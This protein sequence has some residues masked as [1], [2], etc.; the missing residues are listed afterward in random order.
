MSTTDESTPGSPQILDFDREDL[1]DI[2]FDR[3]K[4]GHGVKEDHPFADTVI[5]QSSNSFS[6]TPVYGA[7]QLHKLY[8]KHSIVM[9]T[10][11][12]AL[13]SFPGVTTTPVEKTP[14]ITNS[15]FVPLSKRLAGIPGVLV[16]SIE[17]GALKLEW[18]GFEYLVFAVTFPIGFGTSQQFF[19]L[20]EGPQEPARLLL[21]AS[22]AWANELHEEIWVY[23]QGYWDKSHSL[24]VEV[25]KASWDDVI[26]KDDFKKDLQKDVYGFFESEDVYKDLGIA[27]KRGLIMHGPPGNGKTI[28]LKTIMKTCGEKGFQP[29]YVKSFQSWMGEEA[30]MA[31]VFDKVRELSPCVIILEDLDSLINDRNRSFFLNQVDGIEGNDGLLL[32]G[33]TNHFDRLDPGLSTRPSRFDR[34]FFFDDPDFDARVLYV[35]Y[36]QKKLEPKGTVDFPDSLVT[37]IA[38]LTDKFSFAYLKEAFISTLVTLAGI[39]GEKPSFANLIKS[40][41][42]TLRKQLDKTAGYDYIQSKQPEVVAPK[43]TT[44]PTRPPRPS[45]SNER[46]IRAILDALSEHAPV[47]ESPTR[48]FWA[49]STNERNSNNPRASQPSQAEISKARDIRALLDALSD[50]LDATDIASFRRYEAAPLSVYQDDEEEGREYRGLMDRLTER[51]RDMRLFDLQQHTQQRPAR[52]GGPSFFGS[53]EPDWSCFRPP[54]AAGSFGVFPE[55]PKPDLA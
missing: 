52:R 43:Q 5:K 21:L 49:D 28:S 9:T 39:E 45:S 12:G 32:I 15:F 18:N 17:F 13:F 34:K 55:L 1:I 8:P 51:E 41:I 26:L 30:A 48:R 27:W 35:K 36:W 53:E 33:T 25:Q 10:R 19:I 50:R 44:K 54:A 46:D 37:D 20:H 22:G 14:L 29:L 4:G 40:E 3:P 42:K 6:Y 16:D 38:N 11:A 23:N 7:A 31:A 47:V 24:W 2:F